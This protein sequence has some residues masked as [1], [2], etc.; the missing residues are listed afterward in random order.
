MTNEQVLQ[1]IQHLIGSRYVPGVK[2]YICELTGRA[3][4]VGVNE[5]TTL[6]VQPERIHIQGNAAGNIESFRFG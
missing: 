6:D 3:R 5:P 1:L 2:A 4:V